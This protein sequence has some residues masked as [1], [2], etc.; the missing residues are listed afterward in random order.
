M[1]KKLLAYTL[2]FLLSAGHITQAAPVELFEEDY[3]R[4]SEA[5]L[6]VSALAQF[7]ERDIVLQSLVQSENVADFTAQTDIVFN[8]NERLQWIDKGEVVFTNYAPNKG[9]ATIISKGNVVVNS[10]RDG[11]DSVLLKIEGVNNQSQIDRENKNYKFA[12]QFPKVELTHPEGVEKGVV[13]IED[14]TTDGLYGFDNDFEKLKTIDA[15]YKTGKIVIDVKDD[16]RDVNVAIERSAVAV[17]ID[18]QASIQ[19]TVFEIIKPIIVSKTDNVQ[20]YEASLESLVYTAGAD[21]VD[22]EP[23]VY[24]DFLLKD[25]LVK[26]ETGEKEVRFGDVVV[27]VQ[28]TAL[29]QDLF[30][31][32]ENL[33]V[34]GLSSFDGSNFNEVFKVQDYFVEGSAFELTINGE[35]ADSTA[36]N[37]LRIEPNAAFIA[38]MSEVDLEDQDAVSEIFSG[39]GFFEF[40]KQYIAEIN[41]DVKVKQK[42]IM[43]F[44]SNILL[45]QGGHETIESARKE[46]KEVYQQFMFMAMMANSET[47]VVEF[48]DEGISINIQYKDGVWMINGNVV[49]LEA[50]SGLLG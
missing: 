1:K 25:I 14:A 32:L 21:L 5:A 36:K 22:S 46:M 24:G 38:R 34:N 12:I 26:L 6:N 15:T 42:Y 49:D 40:V 23:R 45:A 48:V 13:V 19:K 30:T 43:E 10:V 2:P 47:S 50:L 9:V 8:D 33:S 29:T 18:N 16:S 41:V 28:L 39:L 31:K 4:I 3:A 27:D 20:A 44:G 35:L 37:Y 11:H 17:E 7:K